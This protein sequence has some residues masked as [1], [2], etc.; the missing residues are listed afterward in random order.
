M[1]ILVIGGSYFYGRVF[2]MEAVRKHRITVLNRGTY[3]MEEFGAVQ[4]TGDRHNAAVFESLQDDYDAVV[5]FCAYEKGD[6]DTVI[7]NISGRIGQYILISTVDVYERG[8]GDLKTEEHA[9]ERRAL[10]GEAGAYIAGKVAVE[11]EVRQSCGELG[12]PWTIFRPAI[13]YGPY[14]YA[15]RES[16]YIQMMLTGHVLP[17]FADADGRFQFVYVKDAAGAV[18]RVAGSEKAFGQCYNLCQDEIVDYNRFFQALKRAADPEIR[19]TLQDI[20][21]TVEEAV[22]KG[23]PVPFPATHQETELCSNEKGKRELH[24]EYL[25]FDEGM[26]RTYNAFKHVYA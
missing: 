7:R 8:T 1:N 22:A 15:P 2:V 13:L 6:V 14:N 23:I 16:A 10:G 5:D 19:E 9:L 3:S 18:L 24:M 21:I 17:L 12:I 26:C 4:V 20:Q 11:D 25:D